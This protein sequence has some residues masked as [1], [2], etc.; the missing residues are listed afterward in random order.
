MTDRR[1]AEVDEI[2]K[3]YRESVDV[4]V[5]ALDEY[6]DA[7]DPS[8]LLRDLLNEIDSLLSTFGERNSGSVEPLEILDELVWDWFQD[9]PKTSESQDQLEPILES[10]VPILEEDGNFAKESASESE[11][12]IGEEAAR[13]TPRN[14]QTK[15]VKGGQTDERSDELIAEPGETQAVSD[16]ANDDQTPDGPDRVREPSGDG[17]REVSGVLELELTVE[18]E[19][20]GD[21]LTE[22]EGQLNILEN[23]MVEVETSAD[24][25]SLNELYRAMHTLKGG[26]GFCNLES[27]TQLTHAAEDLLDVLRDD[28]PESIDSSWMDLLL[29]TLDVIRVILSE[30]QTAVDNGQS[31]IEVGVAPDYL[32]MLENDLQKAVDGSQRREDFDSLHVENGGGAE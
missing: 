28:P 32:E 15:D 10:L 21:F 26:F 1:F 16:N 25:D 27:C 11:D 19:I 30:L 6:D 12:K 2:P 31:N 20:L 29:E 23:M 9:P 14:A 7:N 18:D 5:K 3:P 24:D 22:A 4:L 17:T 13:S 8:G